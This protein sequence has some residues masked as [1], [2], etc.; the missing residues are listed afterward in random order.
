VEERALFVHDGD[1][2]VG[3]ILIQGSWDPGAA[4]GGAVLALLGH[5]LEDVPSLVP[6]TVSRFTAD[7]VRPVPLG[8]RLRV[9]P[10]VLREGKKIQVVQLQLLVDDIEHVRATVLRLRDADVSG[11][12]VPASTTDDRPADAL[13]RPE[14][15]ASVRDRAAKVV[16][17]MR[18]VDMRTAPTVDG[19]RFGTWVRLEVPVVAG[20]PTRPTSRLTVGFDYSNLVGVGEH[21]GTV[22]MINPDVTAHVLRAPTSDWIGITGDTWF[23]PAMGRGVSSATLSDDEGVFAVVSLSQL[24][25]PQ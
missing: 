12:R 25:Q 10:T 4:N 15:V 22:T 5:C 3:T 19:S 1:A 9:V 2:F 6:M 11:S 21:L 14:Q 8:R 20:E 7:L 18:A 16:G 13:V 24:L 17:F 23:N